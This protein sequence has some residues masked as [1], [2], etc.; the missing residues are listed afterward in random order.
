[1]I[2]YL[3]TSAF[4]PLLI[5]EP[6]SA[7]CR[8]FFDDADTVVTSRPTYV[9][10]A[11]ALAQARRLDRIT[12]RIHRESLRSL[13]DLWAQVDI[14]EADERLIRDAAELAHQHNLR[15]YDAIHCA[16]ARQ[17]DDDDLVAA[18]GD[19]QLLQAWSALG[20]ATYDTTNR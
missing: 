16:S 2:G 3:D 11:A 20:I 5:A 17:L 10:T 9:E 19:Q 13:D 7:S 1:M 8:R 12:T 18:T 4:V 14:V 6:S 15:G